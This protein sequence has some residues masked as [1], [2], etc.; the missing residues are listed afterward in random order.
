MNTLKGI[1]DVA[2][3]FNENTKTFYL[4]G[5]EFS[6]IFR[7][8]GGRLQH[9]FFGR[10]IKEQDV[11]FIAEGRKTEFAPIVPDGTESLD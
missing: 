4:N 11:S 2:I 10:K 1:I 9:L 3:R 7:I 8:Y 5:R 6:Y